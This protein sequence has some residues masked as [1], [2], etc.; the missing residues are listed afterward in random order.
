[1]TTIAPETAPDQVQVAGGVDTH[2]DTHTAAAVDT[3]GRLL[4]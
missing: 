3:T 1:M 4:G 2:C